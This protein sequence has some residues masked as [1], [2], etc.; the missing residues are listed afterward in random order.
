VN[1]NNFYHF[2]GSTW[3]KVQYYVPPHRPIGG[4]LS[5]ARLFGFSDKDY[6]VARGGAVNNITNTEEATEYRFDKDHS[7]YALWGTSSNNMFGVGDY[8]V[9]QHF[10]GTSWTQ[11]PKVTEK[12]LQSVWGTSSSNVWAAGFN[13]T[14]ALSVLLHYDGTSWQEI[15]LSTIG[16]FGVGKHALQSVW[17]I[18]SSGHKI[19]VVAGSLLHRRTDNGPWISDSGLVPNKTNDNGFVGITNL[20]GNSSTDFMAAGSWGWI[21]HWDGK[22]WKRYDELFNYQ[23]SFY[24]TYSMHYKGT[25]ACIVG[26]KGGS[27]WI[28]VGKRE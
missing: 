4:A 27:G 24:V 14:T 6:W 28:A 10:D 11:F 12:N 7:I 2:D 18:D 23:N 16:N 3:T 15:D 20:S 8:G 1:G 13:S 19:T 17:A 22:T 5:G 25:T 21:A 9:I 26:S